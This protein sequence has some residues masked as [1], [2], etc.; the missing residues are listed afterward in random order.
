MSR[1][2]SAPPLTPCPDPVLWFS[3]LIRAVDEKDWPMAVLMRD[4]LA[5]LGWDVRERPRKA[6][7]NEGGGR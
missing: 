1:R 2:V 6:P 3:R 7:R 5:S 4:T